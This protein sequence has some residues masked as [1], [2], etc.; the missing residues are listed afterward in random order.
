MDTPIS[1]EDSNFT[2][3]SNGN[4]TLHYPTDKAAAEKI[5]S[6][7]FQVAD[8]TTK[9]PVSTTVS[10]V[11]HATDGYVGIQLPYRNTKDQ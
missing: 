1:A 11:I 2:I 4:Y 7:I 3:N 8:P 6:F 5:Y 10:K 9:K